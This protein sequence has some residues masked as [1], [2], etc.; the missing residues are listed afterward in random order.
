LFVLVELL[1]T[2]KVGLLDELQRDGKEGM[3]LGDDER[4]LFIMVNNM[5]ASQVPPF[6]SVTPPFFPCHLPLSAEPQTIMKL[7][8]V[9]KRQDW[10][11]CDSM[12]LA[13]WKKVAQKIVEQGENFLGSCRFPF[14]SLVLTV[15]SG[16]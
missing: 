8:H 3:V 15:G 16:G 9:P 1:S 5:V 14:L 7:Y 12:P 4:A 6:A 10:L 11:P 13:T 2:D